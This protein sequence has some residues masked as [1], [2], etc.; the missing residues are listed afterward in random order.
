M[1]DMMYQGTTPTVTIPLR[2]TQL[3]VSDI[4]GLSLAFSGRTK[5][6]KTLDDVSIDTENNAVVCTLTEAETIAI[7]SGGALVYQLR[8]QDSNGT[9]WATSKF[10]LAVKTAVDKD[11]IS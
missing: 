8:A 10:T 3:L 1:T 9:V 6:V 7:C 5:V 4:V 2:S 11:V